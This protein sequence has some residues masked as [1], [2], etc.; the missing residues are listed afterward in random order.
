MQ[1]N[2]RSLNVLKDIGSNV[3]MQAEVPDTSTIFVDVGLG[4]F[5]EADLNQA[6]LIL[7]PRKELL[8]Q[9]QEHDMKAVANIEAHI[10]LVEEGLEAFQSLA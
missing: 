4:F 7:K 3:L 8:K 9:K 10:Q 6:I 2:K 1:E 5:A